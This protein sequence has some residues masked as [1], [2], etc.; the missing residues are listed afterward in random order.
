M[1]GIF[2]NKR[3]DSAQ[4]PR[5]QPALCPNTFVLRNFVLSWKELLLPGTHRSLSGFY[6]PKSVWLLNNQN[7]PEEKGWRM[8]LLGTTSTSH[9][10]QCN[11]F[12]PRRNLTDIS[13]QWP[14]FT[15]KKAKA[16]TSETPSLSQT[17]R[18]AKCWLRISWLRNLNPVIFL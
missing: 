9:S 17:S 12:Q 7:L 13:V 10:N 1:T 2:Y 14:H 5:W 3:S 15:E 16:H 11:N 8:P 4:T 6:A 18:K